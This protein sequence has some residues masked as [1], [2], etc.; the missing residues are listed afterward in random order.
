M[1]ILSYLVEA[2]IFRETENSDIEFLL[3]KRAEGEVFA[4]IWQMVT[5]VS[6]KGEKAYVTAIR[7]IGEETGLTPL[8]FWTAPI[9]NSFYSDKKNHICLVPVFA[10][11]TERNSI[12]K[13]SSEHSEYQWADKDKALKLLAWEGQR[14]AVKL[15]HEYYTSQQSFLNFVEIK[16]WQAIVKD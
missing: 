9:V 14:N 12:V 15:I 10:A 2:H 11:L 3:L 16:K 13:I 4:G 8:K 1:K 6:L 5:G 7:E